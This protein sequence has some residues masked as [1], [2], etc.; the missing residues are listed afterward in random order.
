MHISCITCVAWDASDEAVDYTLGII[1]NSQQGQDLSVLNN[2]LTLSTQPVFHRVTHTPV[3][4]EASHMPPS[5]VIFE[6]VWAVPP[7]P[8]TYL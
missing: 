2:A 4:C 1:C 3:G 8:H 7:L 5:R 6:N